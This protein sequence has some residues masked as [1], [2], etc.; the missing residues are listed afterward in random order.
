MIILSL[1]LLSE[2]VIFIFWNIFS[3]VEV[4]RNIIDAFRPYKNN[5]YCKI[6]KLQGLFIGL[7]S[8]P[9][10]GIY[11]FGIFLTIRTIIKKITSN[12]AFKY[13]AFALYNVA[14]CSIIII[15]L[16]NVGI[17]GNIFAQQILRSVLILISI[18]MFYKNTIRVI[19]KY[20]NV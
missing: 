16:E 5:A 4:D 10:L 7:S 13:Y 15:I 3:R 1:I 19:K 9:L 11:L 2:I 6:G 8:I 12:I 18:G 14:V 20:I 17:S